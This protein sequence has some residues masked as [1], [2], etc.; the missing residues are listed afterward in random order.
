MIFSVAIMF[1]CTQKA[2]PYKNGTYTFDMIF[3]E[4]M[5]QPNKTTC[6]VIIK[7]DHIRIEMDGSGN[8]PGKKGDLITEGT[9]FKHERTGKWV[10]IKKEEDKTANEIGG[11]SDGPQVI[12]FE[13]KIFYT[14]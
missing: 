12:D 2:L 14:C 1:A 3:T 11:C 10:I 8:L 4:F 5:T 7:G 6:T 13:K 9:L